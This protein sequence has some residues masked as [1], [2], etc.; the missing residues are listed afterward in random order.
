MEKIQ[1]TASI[2]TEEWRTIQFTSFR[3]ED[4]PLLDRYFHEHHY[5][6]SECAFGTLFIWQHA[7]NLAWAVEDDVLFI[8]AGRYGHE[9]LLPPFSGE[10][11]SFVGGLRRAEAWF[12][13][14]GLPFLLK[15]ASPWVVERMHE[16]C[17]DCYTYT[18]DR[19]NFE[20]IYL[21]SDLINL[22]GKA[23]RQKKNHLN[24]F[25][26]NYIGYEYVPL[27]PADK[28]E[29][30][31]VASRWLEEHQTT[32]DMEEEQQGIAKLFDY[33]EKLAVKGG[34]IRWQGKIVAFSVG[35]YIHPEMAVVHIEKADPTMRGSY[36]AINYEFVRHAWADTTY[37]NRE[38]D[39]G[40]D[41][42]R[43]AKMSYQPH[44]FAEKYDIR[45]VTED[46]GC[47]D[48]EA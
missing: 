21:T 43:Q 33:W 25:R 39:M 34:A 8:R 22:P 17:P 46:C 6:Q 15:G 38:E 20:Y 48:E 36:Q 9:F 1:F 14:Q 2:T 37:I 27:A 42:L 11:N 31:Q 24:A 32:A 12:R 47:E 5:E 30:M 13:E 29:C 4:K 18:E 26:R 10:N 16:L 23:F 35:E 40:I 44:H 45:L 19:D 28:A 3:I 41:G 7:F